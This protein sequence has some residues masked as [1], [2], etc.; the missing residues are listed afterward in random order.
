LL[1]VVLAYRPLFPHDDQSLLNL[2]CSHSALLLE[3]KAMI[4][5]LREQNQE[6]TQANQELE[7][8]AYSVSHDLRTPLRHI[9]GFAELLRDG[10][11]TEPAQV[12]LER[13]FSATGRMTHMI[14]VF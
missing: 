11:A 12:Y 8:F 3:Q 9:E 6:L 2:M 14:D 1:A 4:E 7:A 5:Q 10:L 13:I